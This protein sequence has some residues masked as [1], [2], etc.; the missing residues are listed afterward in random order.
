MFKQRGCYFL[1]DENIQEKSGAVADA[2]NYI[3]CHVSRSFFFVSL[4]RKWIA[5][6]IK[7]YREYKDWENKNK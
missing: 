2:S 5:S 1:I 6:N 7:T 4:R 3:L